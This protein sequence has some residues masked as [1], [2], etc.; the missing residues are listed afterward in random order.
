M[1]KLFSFIAALAIYHSL[2]FSQGCL[3]EGIT[4][5]NQSQVD[6]FQ[7]NYPGC[8]E[9]EGYVYIYGNGVTNLDG[10]SNITSI[11]EYLSIYGNSNLTN[12]AGLNNLTSVGGCLRIINMNSLTNLSGLNSLTSIGDYLYIE[13]NSQLTSIAALS[14][15]NTIGSYLTIQLNNSLQ[16][17]IG[18]N[19]VTSI[20]GS[21]TVYGCP[22]ITDLTGFGNVTISGPLQ[23][24]NNNNLVNLNG[25]ENAWIGGHIY[26][27]NNNAMTS[28]TG[29]ENITSISGS[30][31]IAENNSLPNL[32]GLNN[33]VSITGS[34]DIGNAYYSG[35]ANLTS[36]N[37]LNNLTTI[38]GNLEIS[39]NNLLPNLV[40]LS[41][42][43]SIGG[44]AKIYD[45]NSLSTLMGV[46]NLETINGDLQ[47]YDNPSLVH[48]TNLS[49][50]TASAINNLYI[51]DN[52]VL[53]SCNA[54]AICDFLVSPNGSVNVYQNATGCDNPME[55]A[56]ACGTTLT[57]LPYGNFYFF[58]QTEI[59]NF[60]STYTSC[61]ETDG[62]ISIVGDDITN[63]DGL[64]VLTSLGG[65]LSIGTNVNQN[66][67]LTDISGMINLD[68]IGGNL[69]ILR[70]ISLPNLNGLNN[71]TKIGGDFKLWNNDVLGSIAALGNLETIG[72][73]F[74]LGNNDILSTSAGL[75]TLTTI[76]DNLDIDYNP[77]LLNLDGFSSLTSIGRDLSIEDNSSLTN[78]AGLSN[79][80]SI[81]GELNIDYNLELTSL[82]GLD[83]ID[84]G[85]IEDLYITYN[86]SLSTC[87]V[88]SVCNYL[89]DPD[90]D[91]EIYDNAE[92]CY[93]EY[94]VEDAC[95][96]L[97]FELSLKV[98]LEG[99]F[100]GTN[101]HTDLNTGEIPLVQ[102]YNSPPWNYLGS[103]SVTSVP[104]GV[105]DWLLI[106]IRDA[107]N[108]PS[109]TGSTITAQQAAFLLSDGSV[110]GLNGSSNLLFDQ[111]INQSLFVVIWHR[112]HLGIMSASALSEIGGTYSYDFTTSISQAYNAGQK[113]LGTA[114]GMTAA[115]V[116][117]DGEINVSDKTTWSVQAGD[118]GY[119]TA[120]INMNQ[121]VNNQ[122]KN[123]NWSQNTSLECQ[124]P[125]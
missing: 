117:A 9:I 91:L 45:N 122:D 87:H 74:E 99:P 73:D 106:E 59:D 67:L 35:N 47:I 60:Q 16:N 10:L 83:N 101:M 94:E 36:L 44:H 113:N 115:D 43:I 24:S 96:S 12:L 80:T 8:T 88:Q 86:Y 21:A 68:S 84:A 42:L 5:I 124:V 15:L 112:N 19:N 125:E 90:G 54:Q 58:T 104:T 37:G 103:E 108:A 119:K 120:D 31:T 118:R 29:L 27:Q 22:N 105:V 114:F 64:S 69:F 52:P 51:Y 55:I 78:L 30:L 85:T 17:L 56:N 41:N 33:L 57:C 121:H 32:Q 28:L 100:N 89:A 62:S 49:S 92:G 109:A 82:S 123:D 7:T 97:G 70:N 111:A 72:G 81:G 65:T 116:N 50:L 46:E 25:I 11:G 40:G 6:N 107:S 95:E 1:K 61:T 14:N 79:L 23:I 34:L 98:F 93:D 110:V 18:L 26:I 38:A 77:A 66:P 71:I 53:S 48:I 102:P 76:G 75:E 39:E 4:L 13:G 63:L 2:V 20:G 3:P